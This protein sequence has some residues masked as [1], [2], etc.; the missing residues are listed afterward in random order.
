MEF[1][2]I[3]FGVGIEKLGEMVTPAI[4]FLVRGCER[5][6]VAVVKVLG[7]SGA[8]AKKLAKMTVG[9]TEMILLDFFVQ[10]ES[11]I[12]PGFLVALAGFSFAPVFKGLV[13]VLEVRFL[14]TL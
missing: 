13:G 1:F 5:V 9:R 11:G 4:E 6:A 2:S 8:G 14:R 7:W 3:N 10:L 12:T